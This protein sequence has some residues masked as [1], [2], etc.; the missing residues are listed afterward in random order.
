[1]L[2]YCGVGEV[3][4]TSIL[5]WGVETRV[6][7][8]VANYQQQQSVTAL[9]DGGYIIIW[10]SGSI[11]DYDVFSQRYDA[12][13]NMVGSQTRVNTTVQGFQ[14]SASVAALADGGYVVTW[15]SFLAGNTA[16]IYMQ[17]YTSEGVADGGET[18]ITTSGPLFA[19]GSAQVISLTGGGH[20]VAWVA[21][22]RDGS[23]EGVY[24]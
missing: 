8:T 16:G 15:T 5:N 3:V 19:Q 14:E 11:S 2:A 20:V 18:L 4:M 9:A 6:N 23:L 17:R 22:Q 7:T 13:G 1:M 21:Y 10:Q 24:L 12:Q